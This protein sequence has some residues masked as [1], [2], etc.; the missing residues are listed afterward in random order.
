MRALWLPLH[1]WGEEFFKR[2]DDACGGFVVVDKEMKER[3]FLQWARILVKSNR[4]RVP[5]KLQVV[6]GA[7][8]FEVQLWWEIIPGL[9]MVVPKEKCR[10]PEVR[11]DSK[12]LSQV[13]GRI[14]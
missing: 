4:R 12:G 5:H 9:P 13:G 10:D 1:L 7:N 14:G 6:V 3:C 8:V 11:D 2:F